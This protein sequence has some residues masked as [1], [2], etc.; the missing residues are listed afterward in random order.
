MLRTLYLKNKNK[1]NMKWLKYTIGLCQIRS[2]L[3]QLLLLPLLLQHLP[4]PSFPQSAKEL[5]HARTNKIWLVVCI[6]LLVLLLIFLVGV[7]VCLIVCVT[8][9]RPYRRRRQIE[10]DRTQSQALETSAIIEFPVVP[11]PAI[12]L[13][14]SWNLSSL[15][16]IVVWGAC[17]HFK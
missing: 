16:P 8:S 2:M 1:N 6:I 7:S 14:L 4:L 12:E 15:L 17:Q 13:P 3:R 5:S 10:A 11:S 9:N